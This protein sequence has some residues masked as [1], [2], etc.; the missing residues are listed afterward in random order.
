MDCSKVMMS[1]INSGAT[2]LMNYNSPKTPNLQILTRNNQS[3]NTANL[4]NNHDR[5]YHLN[6]MSIEGCDRLGLD[7]K[8]LLRYKKQE[9][10]KQH[11]INQP[12][13]A[14]DTMY[15][16]QVEAQK[17][18]ENAQRKIMLQRSKLIMD[19]YA[20]EQKLKRYFIPHQEYNSLLPFPTVPLQES[21]QN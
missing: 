2:T 12:E 20:L 6:R 15:L 1:N 14:V 21:V 9:K 3:Q 18:F 5:E 4:S 19:S 10:F 7:L 11:V 13:L 17:L 16:K 8:T